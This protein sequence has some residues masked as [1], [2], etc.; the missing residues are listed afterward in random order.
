MSKKSLDEEFGTLSVEEIESSDSL[1]KALAL[2]NQEG[3]VSDVPE[4]E[5]KKFIVEKREEAKELIN[6]TDEQKSNKELDEI[7]NQADQAFYDLMDIA[8]N[9]TGKA[10][11]DIASAAQ[12]FL[13]IK[14]NARLAKSE[15][16]FKKLNQEIQLKRIEMNSM[17]SS[18]SNE[19]NEYSPEDDIIEINP[20]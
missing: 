20:D 19:V 17:K 16:K 9:S 15:H 3:V 1:Q 4:P 2:I 6:L 12:S 14:L 8:I 5:L 11:G 7:A 18:Q 13:N 10:C